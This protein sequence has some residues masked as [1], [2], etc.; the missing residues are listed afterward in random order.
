MS[1]E[2][3]K[4]NASEFGGWQD[5]AL[6][7]SEIR[8][9]LCC[10]AGCGWNGATQIW[11]ASGYRVVCKVHSVMLTV[12]MLGLLGDPAPIEEA[13]ELAHM[14]GVDWKIILDSEP[15]QPCSPDAFICLTCGGV[16]ISETVGMY[17]GRR[18]IHTC[19]VPRNGS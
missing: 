8:E 17:S 19:G 13:K 16:M 14:L 2:V 5:H 6:G 18:W 4:R 12:M 15:R 1:V 3:F 7:A 10:A 11:T 9:R